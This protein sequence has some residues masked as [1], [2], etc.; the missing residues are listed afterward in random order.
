VK[1]I[2]RLKK[3]A[4]FNR[5]YKK[6]RSTANAFFVLVY[7]KSGLPVTRAGFAVSKKYGKSVKRNRIKR[8]LKEIYRHRIPLIKEGFDLIFVVRKNAR[9]LEFS[10]MER[11]V[12]DL[13]KRARLYKETS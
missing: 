13:L 1:K 12:D 5:T 2:F 3:R 4:D 9:D 11:A 6:G 8:Q 7:R 10:E